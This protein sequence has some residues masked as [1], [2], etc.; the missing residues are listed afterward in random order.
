MLYE[1]RLLILDGARCQ[2]KAPAEPLARDRMP[3][4]PQNR[5]MDAGWAEMNR[6]IRVRPPTARRKRHQ[7]Y[8]NDKQHHAPQRSVRIGRERMQADTPRRRLNENKRQLDGAPASSDH[9]VNEQYDH[10]PDDS[11]NKSCAFI[12]TV[13]AQRLTKERRN[14]RPDDAKDRREN[15]P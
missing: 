9:A 3:R 5:L 13:P 14:K 10:R 11:A 12:R 1:S 2:F 8:R 4:P 15:K 6:F 7:I